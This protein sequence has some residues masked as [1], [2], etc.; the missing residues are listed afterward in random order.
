MKNP[1]RFGQEVSGYQFYDHIHALPGL[2][3]IHTAVRGLQE[4]GIVDT[5]SEGTRLADP[6]FA[7]FIRSSAA[8]VF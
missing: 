4:A 2:S 1:F 7:R 8:R 5:T 3:T 6:F